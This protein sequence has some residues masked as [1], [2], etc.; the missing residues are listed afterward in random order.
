[1]DRG[2]HPRLVDTF[3]RSRVFAA[4]YR[5]GG[6]FV[7]IAAEPGMGKSRIIVDV[8]RAAREMGLPVRCLRFNPAKQAF[9]VA[10]VLSRADSANQLWAAA[11]GCAAVPEEAPAGGPSS[12][13]K[14][15]LLID[16]AHYA[17]QHTL[18]L[19]EGLADE[20]DDPRDGDVLVVLTH[21]PRQSPRQLRTL[22]ALGVENEKVERIELPPFTLAQAADLVGLSSDDDWLDTLHRESAGV[23]LYLLALAYTYLAR[24]TTEP[25]PFG[26][27]IPR[28]VAALISG[29]LATLGPA[30]ATLLR[31]GAVLGDRFELDAA[32]DVAG[33]AHDEALASVTELVRRDVLRETERQTVFAFRHR[34]LRQVVYVDLDVDAR[35]QVHR[36]A[37]EVL[38][39]QDAGVVQRAVHLER[40][41][42]RRRPEDVQVLVAAARELM[43]GEPDTAARFLEAA[44][45]GRNQP[46]RR[47]ELIL[48]LAKALAG[49]RP[50]EARDVLVPL[51]GERAGTTV[52][53]R[54]QAV[55]LCATL[56][57]LSGR[58]TEADGMIA[59]ELAELPEDPPAA[60]AELLLARGLIALTFGHS[61][62]A[63]DVDTAFRLARR[64]GSGASLAVALVLRAYRG[65]VECT[66]A[67]AEGVADHTLYDPPA[68]AL[69]RTADADPGALVLLGWS[70]LLVSRPGPAERHLRRAAAVVDSRGPRPLAPLVNICLSVLLQRRGMYAEGSEAAATA[71]RIAVELDAAPLAEIAKALELQCGAHQEGGT[72]VGAISTLPMGRGWLGVNAATFL[73]SAGELDSDLRRSVALIIHNGGGRDLPDLPAILRPRCYE[74]LTLEALVH[75]EPH[76][77]AEDWADRAHQAAAALDLAC[78]RAYALLAR[79]HLTR[80]QGDPEAAAEL[81]RR[82]GGLFGSAAMI[83]AQA[84]AFSHAAEC[85]REAGQVDYARSLLVLAKAMARQC[86]A[87][88]VYLRLDAQ[89]RD[90]DAPS[91]DE[92]TAGETTLGALTDREREIAGIAGQGKRTKEIAAQ[93]S[94]SPR[95]VDVHL[96]RIYRKLN[97]ESRAELA[98]IVAEAS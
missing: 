48:L 79:A 82:A 17:D 96:G 60:V 27:Q 64:H 37:L 30:E 7:E 31:A 43:A 65:A 9:R 12:G 98:R 32:T 53:T 91:A 75:N 92:E 74:V 38:E 59:S 57:A 13:G 47:G 87:G 85:A 28:Q 71:H 26:A 5:L 62:A 86:G 39:E 56:D 21:R 95:T 77:V 8:D 49:T 84:R 81:Y 2:R 22:L 50:A 52:A 67:D 20:Q 58:A 34:L 69:D 66:G 70:E 78:Q 10:R 76:S 73:A 90:L 25:D 36:A 89:L 93:L 94:L 40:L 18:D 88:K 61:V 14:R 29:E 51:L 46:A 45:R 41:A 24:S 55:A 63:A 3:E 15:V 35:A 11:T 54:A 72:A 42:H 19:L 80:A 1:M 4:L 6:G 44:L 97:I 68:A 83:G 16:D 23:P 33:L